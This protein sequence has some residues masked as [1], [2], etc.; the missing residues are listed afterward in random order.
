MA[1]YFF[2]LDKSKFPASLLLPHFLRFF[3]FFSPLFPI[4]PH[5]HPVF[6]RARGEKRGQCAPPLGIS[7]QFG[8]FRRILGQTRHH[9]AS[10]PFP[11]TAFGKV[12][13]NSNW[14]FSIAAKTALISCKQATPL[15]QCVRPP[16]RQKRPQRR[17]SCGADLRGTVCLVAR[18]SG[19]IRQPIAAFHEWTPRGAAQVAEVIYVCDD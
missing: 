9:A 18:L 15:G 8:A 3:P 14:P 13:T 1:S 10:L 16:P 12:Y 11:K 5:F 7:G 17:G 2:L 6:P 4:L 19:E